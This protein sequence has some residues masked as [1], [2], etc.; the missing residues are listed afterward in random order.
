MNEQLQWIVI[1]DRRAATV[2]ACH[3]SGDG[4]AWMER[5][6]SVGGGHAPELQRGRPSLLGGAERAGAVAAS[7][8]HA[9]P[10]AVAVEH[11]DD[12]ED[13]RFAREIR[14]WLADARRARKMPRTTLFGPARFIGMLRK[15]LGADAEAIAIRDGE[16]AKL[17]LAE[18]MRHPAVLEVLDPLGGTRA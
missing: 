2:Y 13:R 4:K 6:K 17:T 16:F 15:E 14:A 7:G 8:A 18:L 3:A 11:A 10:H 12:E 5:L 9:A 1:A